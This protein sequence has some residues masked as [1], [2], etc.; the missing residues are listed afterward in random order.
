MTPAES[1]M[2]RV[3]GESG[4]SGTVIQIYSWYLL[5]VVFSVTLATVNAVAFVMFC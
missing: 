4:S 1:Q 2:P 3:T 5:L